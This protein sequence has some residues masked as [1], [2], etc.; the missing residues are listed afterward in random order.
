MTAFL[1]KPKKPKKEK[2]G[3]AKKGKFKLPMVICTN[4][5]I[6][7]TEG[8]NPPVEFIQYTACITDTNPIEKGTAVDTKDKYFKTPLM[9]ACA[10]GNIEIVKMLLDKKANVNVTDNFKWTALHHACHG[11]QLEVVKLLMEHG[12]DINALSLNGGTPLTRAIES[13]AFDVV[14]FLIDSGAKLQTETRKGKSIFL[15]LLLNSLP[16]AGVSLRNRMEKY[17]FFLANSN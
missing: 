4:G 3:K 16:L 13:S 7:R 2:G 5:D 10:L 1:G 9:I 6:E 8:G 17:N 12:G 15:F 11:G 14:Q